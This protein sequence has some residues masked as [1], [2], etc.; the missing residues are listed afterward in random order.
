MKKGG[1]EKYEKGNNI[2]INDN[3]TSP[4]FSNSR[5]KIFFYR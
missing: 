4:G 1:E 5:S 3:D 2:I